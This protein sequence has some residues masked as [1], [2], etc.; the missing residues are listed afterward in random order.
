MTSGRFP[1]GHLAGRSFAGTGGNIRSKETNDRTRRTG[2]LDDIYKIHCRSHRCMA[3]DEGRTL[4]GTHGWHG[5]R[6]RNS[7][8]T[9]RASGT[10]TSSRHLLESGELQTLIDGSGRWSVSP[11]TQRSSTKRSP[12]RPTTTS[13]SA[14]SPRPG[15]QPTRSTEE[16]SFATSSMQRTCSGRS[17]KRPRTTQAMGSYRWKCRQR[18]LTTLRRR[19]TTHADC[20]R[21][22]IVQTS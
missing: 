2:S 17:G 3:V 16:S 11:R 18:W 1:T 5:T 4:K 15:K 9:V 22:S 21:G 7:R 12:V 14:N 10:T 19:W 13:R 8:I 6:Y 20:L